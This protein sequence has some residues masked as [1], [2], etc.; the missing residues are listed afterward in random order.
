MNTVPSPSKNTPKKYTAARKIQESGDINMSKNS[1]EK[2]K[3]QDSQEQSRL[4]SWRNEIACFAN[5]N[6]LITL[7]ICSGFAAPLLKA[8]GKE[9]F[10]FHFHGASST[11]KTTLLNIARSVSGV[12][13]RTTWRA[14]LNALEAVAS[15]H[16]KKLLCLDEMGEVFPDE[17]MGAVYR[18]TNGKGKQGA[19]VQ[20][21]EWSVLILSAGE[22]PINAVMDGK[23]LEPRLIDIPVNAKYGLLNDVHS[24]FEDSRDQ[25]T[26]LGR[27]GI[28][29]AGA[30]VHKANS[31]TGEASPFK[32]IEVLG[33]A[34]SKFLKEHLPTDAPSPVVRV[35]HNFAFVAEA[36]ELATCTGVT[37]WATGMAYKHVGECFQT[38]LKNNG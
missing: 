19:N 12:K 7:A 20:P 9:S 32:A 8:A 30:A 15:E 23:R 18:L 1:A 6:P 4:A 29:Y 13:D 10:G 14:A 16:D 33:Y 28:E 22:L 3:T 37:G 38:W 5:D 2:P 21:S 31:Q 35:A 24:S 34:S 27:A 36:G 26:Y 25:I 11:G 17:V